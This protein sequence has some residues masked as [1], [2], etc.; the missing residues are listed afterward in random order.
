MSHWQKNPRIYQINTWVW[1][2]TLSRKLG[3]SITLDNVPDDVILELA[4]YHVDAIWMMGVWHRGVATRKSALNYI[5]EYEPVLPDI[6]EDDIIGS[7]YAIYDYAVDPALGG[8]EALAKFR[9]QLRE[10]GMKLVLDFVPNHV[11]TDHRWITERPDYFIHGDE[12]LI[13]VDKGNFFRS[14]DIQGNDLII[15]HGRDPYF[16][17]WIDSAQFNIFSPGYREAAIHTLIDI[18]SQCDGIRCDMA[19]LA[20]NDVFMQTWGWRGV[21]PLNEEFWNYVMPKVHLHYPDVLF[22]AE[23]YWNLEY[24]LHQQGF[25]YTYDKT[26][27]DRI[28]ERNT[29]GIHVHLRADRAFL[30]QNIRFIENHDEPRAA[31]TLGIEGSRPAAV[32]IATLPGATL[33]HDGQFIGRKAKLPVQIGRQPNE[34][35]YAN[36]Y[37]FYMRILDEIQHPIYK[38]GEWYLFNR[39][40][41]Y[42]NNGHHTNIIAYGWQYENELR[43]IVVNLTEQ[44]SQAKL[45]IRWWQE[46]LSQHDWQAYDVL[47]DRYEEYSGYDIAET[48]TLNVDM[49]GYSAHIYKLSPI[50]KQTKRRQ[51]KIKQKS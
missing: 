1:L 39:E 24:E 12:H 4:S 14:K 15:A 48:G 41:L 23:T 51:R 47:N 6:T 27:Y 28:I 33:F 35:E 42:A 17:G 29:E 13:E 25:Q 7:A 18:S 10:H 16:P 45:D 43:L 36:L 37:A 8:R 46:R 9:E 49:D 11:S 44:W 2:N 30:E 19:M 21:A 5:H 38:H 3:H 22:I 40:P 50:A 20:M 26:L 34:Q 32:L 31:D